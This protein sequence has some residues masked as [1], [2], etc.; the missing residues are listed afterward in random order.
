MDILE[1]QESKTREISVPNASTPAIKRP[2]A[3]RD[4]G[5]ISAGQLKDHVGSSDEDDE[6][7]SEEEDGP[8]V[9]ID[10]SEKSSFT[11]ILAGL[12]GNHRGGWEAPAGS[13]RRRS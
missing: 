12:D 4:P 6:D 3:G 13:H 5:G 7:E 8:P 9:V 1:P 10:K 2:A 11:R